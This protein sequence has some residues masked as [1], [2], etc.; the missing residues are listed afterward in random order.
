MI[1]HYTRIPTT[2]NVGALDFSWLQDAP[3]GKHGFLEVTEDGHFAFEDGT[4]VR[5]MGVNLTTQAAL[6]DRELAP[7]MAEDLARSGVNMVRFHHI[8]GRGEHS[9]LDCSGGS[10]TVPNEAMLDR[11]DYLVN[12]LR[13]RGI[14]IHIDL[15]TLRTYFPADGFTQEE[16]D[17]LTIPTK[18]IHWYDRRIIELQKRFIRQY[19]EHKNPYTGLRYVDDPAVAIVQYVNE[20]GIFWDQNGE[21]PTLFYRLLDE[22]WNAWLLERYGSR[23][24]LAAAW[25]NQAGVV[26]LSS[27]EDPAEGT[28]VQ[29]PLGNWGELRADW[30]AWQ[31][32]LDGPARLADHKRFLAETQRRTFREIEAYLRDEI[33]VRC[34]I[35]ASNLPNG[36]AELLCNADGDVTEHNNYWNHPIGGFRLPLAYHDQY[37]SE[38]DPRRPAQGFARFSSGALAVGTVRK[39]PFVVTEWNCC[40]QT[41]FRVDSLIPLVSYGC[42]QGWD[43]ILLFTYTGTGG[44]ELATERG[45]YAN[46]DSAA[47]PAIWAFFGMAAAIF[48]LGLVRR[49]E[50]RIEIAFSPEDWVHNP[51]DYGYLQQI[52]SF[53]SEIRAVFPE[54]GVYQGDASVVLA[55]GHTSSGDYRDAA[56]A[57][58]HSDNPWRDSEQK[59]R[60]REDWHEL[61]READMRKLRIENMDV[62]LGSKRMIAHSPDAMGLLA[63]VG[64]SLLTDAMQHWGLLEKGRGYSD[65]RVVSDTGEIRFDFG[66]GA[67]TLETP[68][69]QV[70]AGHASGRELD[71][72]LE[73]QRTPMGFAIMSLDG[74]A[75][76]ASKRLL[77]SAMGRCGN[78]NARWIGRVLVDRGAAPVLYEDLR[79]RYRLETEHEAIVC[80]ALSDTGERLGE[81][82][83]IAVPGGFEIELEGHVHYEIVAET[84][85]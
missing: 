35:N 40:A 49:A 68:Q 11:L 58:V 15:H 24:A 46:F 59:E 52:A 32:G 23:D 4:P 26:G 71:G 57:I 62:E 39:K 8:D 29:P 61:H 80:Y 63:H 69:V 84:A 76:S 60:G 83:V 34:V 30:S 31:Q 6:C 5:F 70:F 79:G 53:V 9:I 67:W 1:R 3:A 14:Y 27:L 19:L 43:G 65:G 42:L 48:R 36:P 7:R 74:E 2:P 51:S 56:H 47:D 45:I 85:E 82:A 33:G 78:S 28:V 72:E 20:N 73:S 25:T 13:Q 50:Q 18:S 41:E 54:A 77:I 66:R 44:L 75:R 81:Q 22:M 21:H 17:Q 38:V 12:E 37:L 10:S 55:S 64:H 16:V